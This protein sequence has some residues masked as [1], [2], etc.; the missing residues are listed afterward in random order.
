[1]MKANFL[2]VLLFIFPLFVSAQRTKKIIDR[3]LIGQEKRMVFQEWGD[4]QP[5]RRKFFWGSDMG[6]ADL[7]YAQVWGWMAPK[8]RRYKAGADIRPLRA[9]G[10]ETQRFAK[11]KV[12]ENQSESIK[13]NIDSIYRRSFADMAHNTNLTASADPLYLLYYRRML[14]PL[15][16]FPENPST[17]M[18]WGIKNPA[19]LSQ[20]KNTGQYKQLQQKLVLAKETYEQ[21][22]KL[23][24]PRGK[25]FLMY[26]K[27]LMSWR[28]F[29]KMLFSA[30]N[31]ND[32]Y[33]TY[34]QQL[35]NVNANIKNIPE[36]NDKEI[37]YGIMQRYKYK[38]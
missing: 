28:E 9:G 31:Q 14:E 10:E 19:I 13:K 6:D 33:L 16:K 18:Q 36:Q 29:Q 24:M 15:Q 21:G 11:L 26:H 2:T 20:L 32:L 1:M 12:M 8:N 5:H 7:Q 30:V 38:F 22:R 4:W 17:A 37:V 3:A 34:T 27:A 25:R 23:D 35:K